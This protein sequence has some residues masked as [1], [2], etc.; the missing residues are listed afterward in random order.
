MLKRVRGG[1]E[2]LE[3]L[4]WL[5]LVVVDDPASKLEVAPSFHFAPVGCG[6]K[7]LV[8][9]C[10]LENASLVAVGQPFSL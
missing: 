9:A 1:S 2:R 5:P 7:A 8:A 10:G 4:G 3:G 6:G